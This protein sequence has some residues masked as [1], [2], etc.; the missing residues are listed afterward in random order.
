GP[1]ADADD[2]PLDE[3]LVPGAELQDLAL[4]GDREGDLVRRHQA[5]A[6]RGARPPRAGAACVRAP[7]PWVG[8]H[9]AALTA[10]PTALWVAPW[11]RFCDIPSTAGPAER[12]RDISE[13]PVVVDGA[14][15]ADVG[16]RAA[17]GPAL[18]VH[19][20]RVQGH[21]RV[22]VLDV[23]VQDGDVAAESHRA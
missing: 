12:A 5:T 19:G 8:P 9:P 23:A 18:V 20:D 14:V 16:A 7:P 1:V 10:D 2:V 17:G 11:C 22:G 21:V 4:V 6:C 13:L 3:H 15:G